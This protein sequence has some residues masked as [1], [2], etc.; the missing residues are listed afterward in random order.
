MMIEW[1]YSLK[2]EDPNMSFTKFRIIILTLCLKM[3]MTRM[4]LFVK[5]I[6]KYTF[7]RMPI[8][9]SQWMHKHPQIY[10]LKLFEFNYK[11][12][13]TYKFPFDDICNYQR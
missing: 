5:L 11:L 6:N 7:R 3:L 8:F 12:K 1:I 13:F 10:C 9:H 4:W 2:K